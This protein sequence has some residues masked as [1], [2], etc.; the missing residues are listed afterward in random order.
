MTT[1]M[2]LT[3][4]SIEPRKIRELYAADEKEDVLV[5]EEI[6]YQALSRI[7][8]SIERVK[9]F[10]HV[11]NSKGTYARKDVSIW[12]AEHPSS[13]LSKRNRVRINLGHYAILGLGQPSKG[14]APSGHDCYTLELTDLSTSTMFRSKYLDPGHINWLL[15]HP[16]NYKLMWS[17]ARGEQQ[18]YA[19]KPIPPTQHYVALGMIVTTVQDPPALTALRCVPRA[20]VVPTS[21]SPIPVW[22]DAGSAGGRRGS[23]WIVNSLK[24]AMIVEK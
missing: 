17:I 23:I 2:D 18:M 14:V 13:I 19:W 21:K 22:D 9:S 24:L 6:P 8:V 16:I 20:W 12:D 4:T 10:I 15:P 5:V 3:R 7:Q 11:W 1:D